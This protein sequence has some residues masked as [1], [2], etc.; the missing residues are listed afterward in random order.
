MPLTMEGNIVVDGVLAS[1]HASFNHDLMQIIVTP[2][3]WFPGLMEWI[4]GD[5]DGFHVYA[6]TGMEIGLMTMPLAQISN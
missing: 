4:G 6:K 2:L 3:R 1:C 5:D